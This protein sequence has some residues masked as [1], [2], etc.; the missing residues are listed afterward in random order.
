MDATEQVKQ[1]VQDAKEQVAFDKAMDDH[2]LRLFKALFDEFMRNP[3]T[4]RKL[5]ADKSL[6]DL[7]WKTFKTGFLHGIHTTRVLK[8][9]AE[10]EKHDG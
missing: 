10:K 5:V 3:D 7:C 2:V 4:A 1:V 6:P 9:L 8:E